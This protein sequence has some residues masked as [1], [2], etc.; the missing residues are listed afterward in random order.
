MKKKKFKK[1]ANQATKFKRN[2]RK[3]VLSV[4]ELHTKKP[5]NYK[6]V[7]AEMGIGDAGIRKLIQALLAELVDQKKLKEADKGKYLLTHIPTTLVEGIIQITKFGRGFVLVDGMDQDIL[8]PRGY[9]GSALW[10]DTVMVKMKSGS[11]KPSGRVASVVE[12][13]R[14]KFVGVVQKS[15]N[16]CFVIPSDT[17]VHVDFFIPESEMNGARNGDKVIVDLL[18]WDN[19][20]DSPVGSIAKVLGKPGENDV[21]MHAIMIEFGLPYEFPE[22][23]EAA[24][25]QIPTAIAKAEI[26]KRRDMREVTTFTIDPHDAKD[27][28]DALSFQKLE[29]GNYEIGVHIADVSHYMQ[30]KGILEDE[31][32][33]RAT[34]VYLVDRTIPML[35]EILSNQLCSLRPNEDKL[36]F[37]AVFEMDEQGY[38]KNNWFGRTV[39]HSNRRFTYEEA[40]EVIETGKGDLNEEI[41]IMDKMAKA[42]RARRMKQGAFDFNTE[43]VKFRLDEN[44]RPTGVYLKIMKDSNKL[45]EDFMLLANTGVAEFIG[46]K[47]K[48]EIKT[49]VYRIHD[50]PDPDKV[51]KL[52]EFAHK[53]GYKLPT[54]TDGNASK[55]IQK[56]LKDIQG[57]EEEEVIK[58]MAIRSMAKAEYST[59]NIGHYGLGFGHYSH[60]TSPIRRYP[61]VMVHRL[62]Q[63]YLDGGSSVKAE[64]Y[65][66]KCKHSSIQEKKAADAERASIKYKQVEFLLGKVGEQFNGL[67]S[68]L[69]NQ[70]IYVELEGNKCEGRVALEAMKG[71]HYL[72][73]E[74]R[75]EMIGRRTGHVISFGDTV[76]IKVIGADLIKRHLDFELVEE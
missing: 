68:G 22:E 66:I 32:Y 31:A 69:N 23:V 51:V 2:L 52:R 47:K 25:A 41:L 24:A 34:S 15:K 53:F 21:E 4:F 61:D 76:T 28:D 3:E 20:K 62:L 45:I 33:K 60:F 40:Q 37:S 1:A 14:E 42:M 18:E 57:T 75:Y 70:G 43:E 44:G 64:E 7:A 46:K 16:L 72:F 13:A 10:G 59:D 9:T 48:E 49:F 29:N 6:Q 11:R 55:I 67:V 71:D 5:L 26:E 54:P 50:E 30:P 58:V 74:D 27:F 39:I 17:K 65:E 35:P 8:I 36:C 56:L 12:R 38:V 63:H 19:P 73:D